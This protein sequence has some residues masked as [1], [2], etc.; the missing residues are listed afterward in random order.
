MKTF[1]PAEHFGE[2]HLRIRDLAEMLNIGESTARTLIKNRRG[3]IYLPRKDR[4]GRARRTPL[5]PL[6]VAREIYVEMC[7]VDR[8]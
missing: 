6:E 3:V 2:K 4:R 8:P 5:I 7:T 1:D